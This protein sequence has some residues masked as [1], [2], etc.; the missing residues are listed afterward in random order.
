M[1]AGWVICGWVAVRELLKTA[2]MKS[3]ILRLADRLS[4]TFKN[5]G[6]EEVFINNL[7]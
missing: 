6:G 7:V 2:L 4:L 5:G 1:D 3:T